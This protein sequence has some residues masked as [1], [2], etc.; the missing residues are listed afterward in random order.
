MKHLLLNVYFLE[1]CI[2][3]PASSWNPYSV[4]SYF[5]EFFRSLSKQ[6]LAI[7]GHQNS[8]VI[9]TSPV[10]HGVLQLCYEKDSIVKC[11]SCKFTS[12]FANFFLKALVKKF[13]FRNTIDKKMFYGSVAGSYFSKLFQFSQY[14]NYSLIKHL[15]FLILQY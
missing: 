4:M 5:C 15:F 2:L 7:D 13:M 14:L 3:R 9:F 6:L 11:F 12:L 8:T 1:N 10:V